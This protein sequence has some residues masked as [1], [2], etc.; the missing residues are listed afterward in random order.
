L[1]GMLVKVNHGL[2]NLQSWPVNLNKAS[3]ENIINPTVRRSILD[4]EIKD[5]T[6][7]N[8]HYKK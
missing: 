8:V 7:N 5:D 6:C 2:D 4:C 1:L 3:F